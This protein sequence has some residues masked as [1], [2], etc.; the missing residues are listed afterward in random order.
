MSNP[1]EKCGREKDQRNLFT[2]EKAARAQFMRRT[3]FGLSYSDLFRFNLLEVGSVAE[4][5]D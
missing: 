5:P 3:D 1:T 2:A 4:R